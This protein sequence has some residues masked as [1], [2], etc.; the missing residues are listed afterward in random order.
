MSGRNLP[1]IV[2]INHWA[3]HLGGAEHSLRD[4]LEYAAGRSRCHLVTSEPGE[5]ARAA[6]AA[7]VTCH[8][9]RCAM[10]QRN[11]LRERIAST[12]FFSIGDAA[13]FLGYVLRLRRL[14][15]RLGPDLIHAN[16]PKSHVALFLLSLLGYRGQSCFHIR[17]LFGKRSM[18]SVL[19]GL[20]FP[21][22][23]AAAIAISQAV[24]ES[25]PPRVR[26][27]ST[28]VYNGVAI[29]KKPLA[30]ARGNDPLR[31]LYLGRIV[32][33]KGCHELVDILAKLRTRFPGNAA[34]LS[35]VGDSSYWSREYRCSLEDKIKSSGLAQACSLLPATGDVRGALFCHDVF[36]NGSHL[37]PFGR[38]IAE[39]QG[40]GLPVVSFDSGGVK[41]I[42]KHGETGFL[43]P[44]GNQ[45]AFVDAVAEFVEH[46]DLV[47]TMGDRG[48][49]RAREYFNREIQ[50][51]KI[52]ESITGSAA[53]PL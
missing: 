9:V 41:E 33:W 49:E 44:Y 32:P 19:Y 46:P 27:K 6:A 14:V 16:V 45:E 35:L 12:I 20:L 4:L 18:P 1:T 47:R 36:V 51:P 24:Q 10:R 3:R 39:A 53:T 34:A 5:L 26:T 11:F 21:M 22:R 50:V 29:A 17:E 40:A 52:W 25:L 13:A 48:F 37:E 30:P 31:L 7:G 38:S 42:V 8:V 23:N 43:V 2:F 15:R 28:V